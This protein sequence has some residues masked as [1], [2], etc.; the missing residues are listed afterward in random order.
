MI[1][2]AIASFGNAEESDHERFEHLPQQ[3]HP[4]E[5]YSEQDCEEA[6]NKITGS[7][8]LDGYWQVLQQNSRRD[9]APQLVHYIA[10]PANEESADQ[11]S[12]DKLPA[13]QT[14]SQNGQP[15]PPDCPPAL[16]QAP[17][18]ITLQNQIIGEHFPAGHTFRKF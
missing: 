12:A 8:F 9:Q 3:S 10:R 2:G 16:R 15:Q 14:D 1:N 18:R 5:Q 17:F 6:A 11:R 7:R 4:A 13:G